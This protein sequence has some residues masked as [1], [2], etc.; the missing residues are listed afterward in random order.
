[1]YVYQPPLVATASNFVFSADPLRYRK[2]CAVPAALFAHI[3]RPRNAPLTTVVRLG[4]L[5]ARAKVAVM[6]FVGGL[7]VRFLGQGC[8][9]VPI[10]SPNLV[11]LCSMC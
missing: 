7:F 1:M 2:I 10:A 11:Q 4:A 3:F 9:N 5:A 6:L 8:S